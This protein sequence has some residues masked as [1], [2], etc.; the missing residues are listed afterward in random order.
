MARPTPCLSRS[1]NGRERHGRAGIRKPP[2]ARAVGG[3]GMSAHRLRLPK[4]GGEWQPDLS[5]QGLRHRNGLPWD[6]VR[7]PRRNHRCVAQTRLTWTVDTT[8]G[9][10]VGAVEWCAC[11]GVTYSGMAG[12][13]LA[14]NVRR[15]YCGA[16]LP[17]WHRAMTDLSHGPAVV[18]APPLPQI[19]DAPIPVEQS[20]S[21]RTTVEAP[22]SSPPPPVVRPPSP[23][24]SDRSET[25][26]LAS[27]RCAA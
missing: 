9:T 21:G 22:P 11:G 2:S 20:L 14:K 17:A 19:A 13:W 7:P 18:F 6:Q 12:R 8:P 15:N 27:R 5:R 1:S 25:K 10:H 23:R 26:P 3:S 24:G 16:T 4:P